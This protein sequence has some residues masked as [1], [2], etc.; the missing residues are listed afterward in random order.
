[1]SFEPR[2]V[3]IT[4]G[5]G[6][7]GAN[8]VRHWLA[9][10]ARGAG[11]GVRCPDLCRQY[12]QSRGPGPGPA[13]CFR[14]GRYLRRSRGA[15][16]ARAA[17]RSIPSC[18]SRRNRMSIGRSWVPDDFIRTNIVGTHALLKAA[19]ALWVDRKIV[20]AHRFHHVS[21]DEVYGSLGP[22]DAPFHEATPYAPNS[23]YSASKAAS[24]H[25][26]RAYYETFGLQSVDHQL[27][28]QLRAVPVSGEIDPAHHR[29][30][31][32]RQ[33]AA[34][35]RRRAAGA[36]LAACGRS[37]RGDRA[38][39]ENAASRARCTTSAATAKRPISRSCGLC[40]G[41]WMRPSASRSDLR[42]AFPS[43]PAVSGTALV[44]L[45]THVRDR[46]GTTAATRS[47]TRRRSASWVT[48]R[49]GISQPGL[50]ATL[51]WYLAQYALVAGA[52]GAGLRELAGEELQA[53]AT[54][55][56]ELEPGGG[57]R[58]GLPG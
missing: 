48:R 12:R 30:H 21:T 31:F 18:I 39:A 38:G 6:F 7:I 40:A 22:E 32:A 47:T 54:P 27:L 41:W 57:A 43:S 55:T 25:L 26:V 3:F 56:A 2:N 29:Q 17:S 1:M 9:N 10:A 42:E 20:P 34:G 45:I 14:E 24:D 15:R 36:R 33:G 8:F 13:V 11:G 53:L 16:A 49:R 46:P 58:A 52:V 5:A 28:E 37:L 50:R 4:G 19:K 51:D 35:V 44:D 23:P